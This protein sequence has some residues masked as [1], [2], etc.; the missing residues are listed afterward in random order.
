MS[1]LETRRL[2]LRPPDARDVSVITA[3]I[4]EWDIVKNLSRAPYPYR[5]E[6]AREFLARLETGRAQG[7]DFAFALTRKSDAAFMGMCGIHLRESGFELGYWLGKPYWGQGFATE[8]AGR[9]TAFA[10]D[11]LKADRVWAGWFHDNPASGHVLEK[12]GFKA[13]G[14]DQRDC[15]ARGHGVLCQLV[16]LSRAAFEQ[17]CAA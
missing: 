8:A 3:L 16:T 12:L 14:A 9:A 10:F 15:L 6:H 7:T 11:E 4:G 5:E 13:D 17:R 2:L 1:I